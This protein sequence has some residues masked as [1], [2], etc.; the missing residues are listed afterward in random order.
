MPHSHMPVRHLLRQVELYRAKREQ[1]DQP[2]ARPEWLTG[3]IE[4][5]AALFEP[6]ADDGR[7][8]Y[9]CR[10]VDDRWVLEMYLGA[11]E[12]VGGSEDGQLRYTNFQ[13]DLDGLCERFDRLDRFCWTAIPDAPDESGGAPRSSVM[14][15]GTVNKEPLRLHIYSMPP[16][17]A[18]PGFREFADGRREPVQ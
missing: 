1:G 3:F 18:G 4:G 5:I 16:T 9:D 2:D 17:D 13:F 15:S 12:M 6:L 8:G 11:T 7:A 10:L 14:I